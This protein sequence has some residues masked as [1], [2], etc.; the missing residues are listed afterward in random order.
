[1]GSVEIYKNNYYTDGLKTEDEVRDLWDECRIQS[2]D[3]DGTVVLHLHNYTAEAHEW[4]EKDHIYFE[5]GEV[6]NNA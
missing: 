1:M 3:T 2:Q 4:T 6:V 5:H